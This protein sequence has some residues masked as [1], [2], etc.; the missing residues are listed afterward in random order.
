MG[1]AVETSLKRVGPDQAGPDPLI[2]R[3]SIA[4]SATLRQAMEAIDR[5][6]VEMALVVNANGRLVGLVTD[7]DIRRAILNGA[8]TESPVADVLNRH[9]LT[10][11]ESAQ[12]DQ[13]L[14]AMGRHGVRQVPLVD[15]G[16]RVRRIAWITDLIKA[17]LK[18]NAVVIMAGGK[19]TR[20]WPLTRDVPKPMLEIQGRPILEHII[21]R[22]R[23][24]GL[25]RITISVQHLSE[26]IVEH[27]GAGERLGVQIDYLH[28]DLP[29]GTAGALSLLGDKPAHPM[30]VMN[31]D[32]LE[33]INFDSLLSFHDRGQFQ[34]TMCCVRQS[35]QLPYGVVEVDGQ[36]LVGVVEKPTQTLNINA[37]V[38]VLN[39]G[40]L[41]YLQ[42]NHRCDMTDLMD[43]LVSADKPV[44]VFTLL[45]HEG[46]ADIGCKDDYEHAKSVGI[47]NP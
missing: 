40:V 43:R 39:P 5:G 23:E 21:E 22:L 7:G 9:P 27:F 29:L 18:P 17:D 16:G 28:E 31:G 37:G 41:D 1:P 47:E 12:R 46:W 10:L 6:A 19:G 36:R 14:A 11:P 20:L 45:S 4:E 38:Y 42:P 33:G 8:V 44:G 13:L 32:L 34:A 24:Y 15:Q 30:I 25:Y 2:E 35:V 26:V 3:I